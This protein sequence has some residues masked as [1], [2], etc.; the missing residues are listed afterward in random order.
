[1]PHNPSELPEVPAAILRNQVTYLSTVPVSG[2]GIVWCLAQ[3]H[4]VATILVTGVNALY[5]GHRVTEHDLS[6]V[7]IPRDAATEDAAT[8]CIVSVGRTPQI[9]TLLLDG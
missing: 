3:L 6:R 2:Q 9:A 8:L 4:A 7:L 1:M 5:P